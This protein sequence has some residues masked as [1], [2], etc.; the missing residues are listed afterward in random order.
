[1]STASTDSNWKRPANVVLVVAFFTLL[2]LPSLDTFLHFD[3]ASALNEKRRPAQMPQFKPGLSGLKPEIAGLESYFNDH[4]GCRNQLIRWHNELQL[5]LSSGRSDVMLGKDGWLY[6]DENHMDLVG[7]Y[8]GIVQF[9]PEELLQLKNIQQARR[10][11]LA[12]RGI[13]YLYVIAPDKQSIYPEYLPSWLKP[14]RHHT[15]FDQFVEYMRANSSVTVLDLRPALRDAR[16]ISPTYYKT[17]SHWNSF[18][19][20]VASQE[21]LKCL[22]PNFSQSGL[23]SLDSF[24]LKKEK[25]TGGDLTILLGGVYAEEDT[26]VL[27]PKPSLPPLVKTLENSDFIASTCYTTNSTAAGTCIVFRDSFGPALMPFLGYH[28]KTVGYFWAPGGFDTNTVQTSKPD[29]VISE[30]VERHF[31]NPQK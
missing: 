3:Q 6:F 19:G 29:V 31:N 24:E 15:K 28:F 13:Q 11:W 20:F 25:F 22:P 8:Q 23:T 12:Q 21:I 16:Q 9:S 17:D 5:A 1:M 27:A 30:I 2:W 18:G 4:F 26:F 14:V 10:D 7:N